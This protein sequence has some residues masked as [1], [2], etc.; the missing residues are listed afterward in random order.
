VP[1]GNREHWSA[2]GSGTDEP[3]LGNLDHDLAK[4]SAPLHRADA[5]T[6]RNARNAVT[7]RDQVPK[8]FWTALSSVSPP[9]KR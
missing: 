8:L 2:F 6:D 9:T 5:I 1:L 3:A 7:D 4:M